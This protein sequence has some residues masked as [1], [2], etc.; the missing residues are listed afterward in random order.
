[1]IS[2]LKNLISDAVVAFL[3]YDRKEDDDFPVGR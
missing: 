3:Y 2:D 1:M